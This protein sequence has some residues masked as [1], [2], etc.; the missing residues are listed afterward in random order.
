MLVPLTGSPV[1]SSSEVILKHFRISEIWWALDLSFFKKEEKCYSRVTDMRRNLAC[2]E[3]LTSAWS[4]F[5]VSRLARRLHKAHGKQ[6]CKWMYWPVH[7]QSC[8]LSCRGEW[9]SLSRTYLCLRLALSVGS[10]AS[11]LITALR[12]ERT[13]YFMYFWG[14]IYEL[15]WYSVKHSRWLYKI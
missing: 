13:I 5:T 9:C 6:P 1:C 4:S 10:G 3:V 7:T 11:W 2:A 14:W 12:F 8:A 15:S